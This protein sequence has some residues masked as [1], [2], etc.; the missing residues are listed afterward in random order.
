M[1]LTLRIVLGILLTPLWVVMSPL[2]V[3]A[4]IILAANFVITGDWPWE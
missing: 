3:V 2:F 4:A 1:K